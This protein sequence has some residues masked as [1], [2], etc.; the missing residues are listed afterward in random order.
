MKNKLYVGVLL[1][2]STQIVSAQSSV[3]LY[4]VADI[5]LEFLSK[6]NPAGNNLYRMTTGNISASR[7]GLRGVED[8][9]GDQSSIRPGEW[10]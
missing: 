7:W 9:G 5:G 4:G 8:L 6:A 3:T 2:I 1:A 10:H